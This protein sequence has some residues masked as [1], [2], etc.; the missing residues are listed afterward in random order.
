[1]WSVPSGI[2]YDLNRTEVDFLNETR[3]V[4]VDKTGVWFALFKGNVTVWVQA[5]G[6]G[7][8][9][10]YRTPAGYKLDFKKAEDIKYKYLA[11]KPRV[12]VRSFWD[13]RNAE[14]FSEAVEDLLKL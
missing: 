3:E 4:I 8:F 12:L 1:M 5:I 11:P 7:R 14:S 9:N 13:T 2:I 6:D 10:L